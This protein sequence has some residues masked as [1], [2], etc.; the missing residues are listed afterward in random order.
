MKITKISLL[1]LG[2]I[3]LEGLAQM[4]HVCKNCAVS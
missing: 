4:V 3:G 2:C 1:T